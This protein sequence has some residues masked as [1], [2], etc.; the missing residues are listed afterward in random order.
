LKGEAPVAATLEKLSVFVAVVDAGGFTQ[1]AHALGRSQSSVSRVVA[2]LEEEWGVRLFIRNGP[3][4]VLTPDGAKL[5]ARA[6]EV[7]RDSD[8][9]ER[10]A[11]SIT[12]LETGELRLAAPSSVASVRLAGPVAAFV[13]DHPRVAVTIV[14]ATYDEA[15][16]LMLADEADLAF[17]DKKI[18]NDEFSCVLLERDELIVVAPRNFF[19]APGP[20]SMDTVL[21]TPFVGDSETVPYLL[22]RHPLLKVRCVTS[23]I[24][25]ILALV[26]AGA[27]IS[28][29]PKL[30]LARMSYDV[31]LRPL[32]TTAYRSVWL[33]R[34]R[35]L[36]LSA[37]A[38]EFL[39]YIN[40]PVPG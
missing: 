26:E 17:L 33:A 6:R 20:V 21:A 11:A 10:F 39:S 4:V 14:E 36:Q 3:T 9:L 22:E 13:R 32:S 8:S 37:A 16:R 25:V 5:A 24:G 18:D 40:V 1:A 12:N 19:D 29:L 2:S 30:S 28:I 7:C 31:D 27:G 15:E 34:R 35:K 23:D 38:I